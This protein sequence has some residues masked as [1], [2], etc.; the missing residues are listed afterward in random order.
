[1]GTELKRFTAK[2]GICA[3]ITEVFK[4]ATLAASQSN[5][6]NIELFRVKFQDLQNAFDTFCEYHNEIIGIIEKDDAFLEE[7]KVRKDTESYFY[8]SKMYYN[9]IC[10]HLD[11]EEA[12]QKAARLSAATSSTNT[13]KSESLPTLNVPKFNGDLKF[14]PTFFDMYSQIVHN[15]VSISN[16]SKLKYLLS[17][18]EGEPQ[19]L[20]SSF[21]IS[22]AN[23]I[24]AYD[25]LVKRYQNKR[26]LAT[27]AIN[28]I[29][30]VTCKNSTSK[31][32]RNLLNTFFEAL[33]TLKSVN[34][35]VSSWCFILFHLLLE[36]TPTEF[37][38]SFEIQ[39][40]SEE[41]PTFKQ[42]YEFLENRCKALESVQH[43]TAPKLGKFSSDSGFS[44]NQSYQKTSKP[45]H[46]FNIQSSKVSCY[47][48]KESHGLSK[49][50]KFLEKS[51]VDRN[52]FVKHNKL[53]QNCLYHGHV[54]QACTSK[55]RCR[56]SGCNGKHHTSVHIF[57]SSE[58]I[59]QPTSQQNSTVVPPL[60]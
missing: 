18:L 8:Q 37:R 51:P 28:S 5:D 44:K 43:L 6:E 47:L 40:S 9:R 59:P 35:D 21:K 52:N 14:W 4:A 19:R 55:F 17:Y 45:P 1:M 38:T 29:M 26:F 3:R 27:N 32:V 53:C 56:V 13:S 11:D 58:D 10:K 49:C 31:D 50:S 36:K 23:Y 15:N 39:Y 33:E 22:D 42:L 34:F 54:T 48:C 60:A 25:K 2:R 7:D 16:A 24:L 12:I 57:K 41:I 30:G 46:V 20:L